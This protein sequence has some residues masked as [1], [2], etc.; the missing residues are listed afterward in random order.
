[1]ESSGDFVGIVIELASG[2]KLSK[3]NLKG[4]LS[5]LWMNVY[6]NASSIVLNRADFPVRPVIKIYFDIISV[7]CHSLID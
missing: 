3:N 1:M 6:R 4:T 5:L 7:S 2:M